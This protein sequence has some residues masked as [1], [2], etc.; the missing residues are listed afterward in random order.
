MQTPLRPLILGGDHSV[1]YPVV[2]A[3]SEKLGGPIDILH[4]DAHPDLY[5]NFEDNYYSHASQFAQIVEGKH[6]NRLVQVF[7]SNLNFNS[8]LTI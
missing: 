1:S 3:I 8:F 7:F 5:E 2:R 4:F 6:V